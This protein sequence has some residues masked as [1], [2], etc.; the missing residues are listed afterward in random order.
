M[1][2]VRLDLIDKKSYNLSDRFRKQLKFLSALVYEERE[3]IAK[4][5]EILMDLNSWLEEYRNDESLRE[6]FDE[7]R[8]A[9]FEGHNEGVEEGIEQGTKQSKAEI[10]K[11]MLLETSDLEFISRTTS[12]S[13]EEVKKLQKKATEKQCH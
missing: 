13:I 12:L 4:G 7:K 9:R 6:F 10:A 3:S 2:I 11:R 5:D 1:D 8:W